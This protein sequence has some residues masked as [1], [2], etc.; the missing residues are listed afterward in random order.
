MKIILFFNYIS[1][2]R[3][4]QLFK[5]N[6]IIISLWNVKKSSIATLYKEV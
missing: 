1:D 6:L 5:F 3:M 2:G 4:N